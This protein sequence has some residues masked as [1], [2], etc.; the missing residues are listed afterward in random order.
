MSVVTTVS[1]FSKW[2]FNSKSR[3][4]FILILPIIGTF[5]SIWGQGDFL[6]KFFNF[7]LLLLY[8]MIPWSAINIVDFYL[9]RKGKYNDLLLLFLVMT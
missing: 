6:D 9:V 8:F 1:A 5:L 3:I 2:K 7:L 4:L